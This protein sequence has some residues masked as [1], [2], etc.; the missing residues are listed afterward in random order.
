MGWTYIH[1]GGEKVKDVLKREFTIGGDP[2][3]VLDIAI[4]NFREAY[5]AVRNSK[6]HVFAL[7]AKLD[8]VKDERSYHDFGFNVM[9]EGEGPLI[10][11]A[12]QR[13]LDL[14]SPA[15]VLYK[16]FTLKYAMEWRDKA[17]KRLAE[18]QDMKLEVGDRIHFN[19]SLWELVQGGRRKRFARVVSG[20]VPANPALFKLVNWKKYGKRA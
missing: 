20:E 5:A 14:L 15:N 10:H 2:D 11:A 12:P 4:V 6:G 16:G 1:R 8:Y 3:S 7:V 17:S 19:G 18:R 9:D 13:I